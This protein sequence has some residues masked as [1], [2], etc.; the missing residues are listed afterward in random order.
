M[1]SHRSQP[2]A[3]D[4]VEVSV[5]RQWKE[6]RRTDGTIQIYLAWN[7]RFRRY[8]A[9]RKELSERA[10]IHDVRAFA[11][12]FARKQ[13]RP[14]DAVF[15]GARSAVRAWTHALRSL[16]HDTPMWDRRQRRRPR[17]VLVREFGQHRVDHG[18]V[19]PGTIANESAVAIEF[20]TFLKRRG[21]RLDDVGPLDLDRFV[22]GL[23]RRLVPKTISRRCSSLRAFLRFLLITKRIR[24]DLATLVVGPRVIVVD[25]PPKTVEWRDVQMLMRTIDPR[26]SHGA[27]NYAAILLMAAYGFGAAEVSALDLDDIDWKRRTIHLRRPKTGGTTILPLLPALGRALSIYISRWRPRHATTRALFV[28]HEIPHGRITPSAIRFQVAEY[29]K[30][31]G[32]SVPRLAGHALRHTHASRQIDLG[33]S[34]KVVSDILGHRSPSS[35]SVYVRVAF[36]RLRAIAL[37]VPR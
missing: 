34:A 25:H 15:R 1:L 37:P 3:R 12:W 29:G 33:T 16:G 5:V 31:A 26:R 9:Q 19:T 17:S 8:Q 2:G 30:A 22:Q 32:V 28:L 7:R 21:R 36:R 24:R 14:V 20:L 10:S 6:S 13:G 18:G 11:R 4:P 27:R 23:G 35:T